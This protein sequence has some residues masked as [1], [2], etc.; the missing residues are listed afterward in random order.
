[1]LPITELRGSLPLAL[2]L[3]HLKIWGAFFF[4]VVGNILPIFI[5]L[6][7]L[8]FIEKIAKKSKNFS[9]FLNWLFER[10]RKKFSKK[11]SLYRDLALT[12]F[13]AIP[14][15]FTGAWTGAIAAFLFGIPYWRAI[16][17]IFLGLLISGIIVSLFVTGFLYLI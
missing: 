7:L 14:L 1:M 9:Y 15:P 6:P 13:V 4:S 16:G 17:L 5:L 3:Y 2:T 10:T 8:S 11:Y 12:I